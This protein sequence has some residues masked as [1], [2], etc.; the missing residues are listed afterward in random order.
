[1]PVHPVGPVAP[2]PRHRARRRSRGAV[3]VAAALALTLLAVACS[4]SSDKKTTASPGTTAGPGYPGFN[5]PT[6]PFY[7]APNP[8]PAGQ[9][10]E[11]IRQEPF[12]GAPAGAQAWRVIY[13]STAVDGH[14]IAVSGVIIA[15]T[16]PAPTGGR[17]ILSWAHPTTGVA[18]TCA[19]S[20]LSSFWALIPGLSQFLA[21]GYAVAATDYEGL[22]TAGV[23]PYLVGESEGRGVLDAAR[24]A[25][26]IADA[27][28]GTRLLVWGHSQGGQAAL[29]AGQLAPTYAPE[30]TL[31]GVAAAAPAGEL[32]KLLELQQ[33]DATGVVLGAYAMNAYLAVYGPAHADMGLDQVV[34]PAGQSAMAQI[35]PLCNLTQADQMAPIVAPVIGK[36]FRPGAGDQ[37]PWKQLLDEN[38]PGRQKTNVPV[39][40][41]QGT[42]DAVVIPSTTIELANAMCTM[43]DSLE[44]KL[45]DGVPHTTIGYVSAA[46]VAAWL[47]A[48][49]QGTAA[50]PTCG[51]AMPT[52]PAPTTTSAAPTTT[53][54]AP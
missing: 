21:A 35:V 31:A 16:G 27:G 39:L 42:A 41:T 7:I 53:A 33:A 11:I 8:L 37:Q 36:F 29:F 14:D 5:D 34:T 19:P 40:I 46:D 25:R 12:P 26:N 47:A 4:G 50:T 45:Y 48:R 6:D 18:D 20:V 38:S 2:R 15:P 52:L 22:G 23:H 51:S 54:A 17:P 49:L 3:V 10:G 9:P 13:H 1:M 43:G 30:L 24:A 28:A 32:A 44:V